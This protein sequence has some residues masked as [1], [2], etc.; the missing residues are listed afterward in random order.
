MD[1]FV[2]L[3]DTQSSST[4]SVID[5]IIKGLGKFGRSLGSLASGLMQSGYDIGRVSKGPT[6]T[7]WQVGNDEYKKTKGQSG[8]LCEVTLKPHPIQSEGE[9]PTYSLEIKTVSGLNNH[10]FVAENVTEDKAM[11][12][13]RST[14]AAW[15]AADNKNAES[16]KVQHDA[17]VE[18]AKDFI[19]DVK[20]QCAQAKQKVQSIDESN[21]L[22]NAIDDL[23]RE[24][25]DNTED[26]S[27]QFQR[28]FRDAE[29]TNQKLQHCTKMSDMLEDAE[30]TFKKALDQILGQAPEDQ[31]SQNQT[32]SESENSE[33]PETEDL[34]WGKY[35]L[36]METGQIPSARGLNGRKGIIAS[37]HRTPVENEI[38]YKLKRIT[39]AQVTPEEIVDALQTVL[40]DASV[41][42][43][44]K[45][46][47]TVV[48]VDDNEDWDVT[49]LSDI[50]TIDLKEIFNIVFA[51]YYVSKFNLITIQ[52]NLWGDDITEYRYLIE[53]S[54]CQIDSHLDQLRSLCFEQVHSVDNPLTYL[55]CCT[56]TVPGS[57]QYTSDN[58]GSYLQSIF[59]SIIDCLEVYQCNFN[60][61]IQ[62]FIDKWI[63]DWKDIIGNSLL[64][65]QS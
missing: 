50:D 45:D 23:Q 31:Q 51:V 33:E 28:A 34:S 44:L 25:V 16:I 29:T 55:E 46:D 38:Q 24:A 42:D 2:I 13:I 60:T 48:L 26:L 1:K 61:N 11:K 40:Y 21:S 47:S 56:N 36:D 22:S 49:V 63:A 4:S 10:S 18:Q 15:D 59:S 6:S 7:V 30:E 12:V 39:S 62:Q 14:M 5:A 53:S 43:K 64:K 57:I 65:L 9:P 32:E 19:Q 54:M 27:K 58:I 3:C 17:L 52:S 37:V 20:T 8:Y 35:A 41:Q